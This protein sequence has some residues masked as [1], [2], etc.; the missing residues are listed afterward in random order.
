MKHSKMR[1]EG[2]G[3]GG[4]VVEDRLGLLQI[5]IHFGDKG[6]PKGK[7]QNENLLHLLHSIWNNLHPA[8][9]F[10][11]DAVCDIY[12]VSLNVK[13]ILSWFT[14]VFHPVLCS[15]S[16]HKNSPSVTTFLAVLMML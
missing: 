8:R 16:F 15:F 5:N 2:A 13:V 3:G 9:N 10:Y 7:A 12:E 1:G 11:T 14:H 6:C 4:G